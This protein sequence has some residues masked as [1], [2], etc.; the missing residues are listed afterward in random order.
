ML[1]MTWDEFKSDCEKFMHLP[2]T[3]DDGWEIVSSGAD[4]GQTYLKII[5]K[6]Q[7][8]IKSLYKNEEDDFLEEDQ[9]EFEKNAFPQ[10]KEC[11]SVE[12]NVIYSISYQVPLLFFRGYLSSKFQTIYLMIKYFIHL[13]FRWRFDKSRG[14]MEAI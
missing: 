6:M 13:F 11:I 4:V 8:D 9:L 7:A 10:N 12:Y 14:F 3:M 2:E 1:T 5:K